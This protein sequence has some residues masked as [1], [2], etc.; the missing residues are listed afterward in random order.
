MLA[1]VMP[2]DAF[3]RQKLEMQVV[4]NEMQSFLQY[5]DK[6]V[7]PCIHDVY[8][9]TCTY[10][11]LKTLLKLVSQIKDRAAILPFI[12]LRIFF[13]YTFDLCFERIAYA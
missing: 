3:T 11:S 12:K 8:K 4:S 13:N 7:D 2:G 9:W 1:L 5:N 6:Y 10:T